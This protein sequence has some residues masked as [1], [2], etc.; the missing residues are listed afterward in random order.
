MRKDTRLKVQKVRG[1]ETWC[2]IFPS[3]FLLILKVMKR[4]LLLLFFFPFAVQL[5]AGRIERAYAALDMYDYFKARKL[6]LKAE[7]CHPVEAGYGL[8]I[9]YSRTDNPFHD[10][11]LAHSSITMSAWHLEH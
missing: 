11:S 3:R 5:H 2:R 7:K 8:A 9:I 10:I 4:I 1:N 6:F